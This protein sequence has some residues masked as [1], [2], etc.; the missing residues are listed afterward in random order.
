MAELL[1]ENDIHRYFSYDPNWGACIFFIALFALLTVAFL[2]QV[3]RTKHQRWLHCL[4]LFAALEMG[5]YIARIIMYASPGGDS[6]KAELIILILAPNLLAFCCYVVL[7]K[8]I[9]F[10]FFES[11]HST[12]PIKSTNWIVR[13]PQWIPRLYVASDILCLAIQGAGGGMLSG[14][15]TNSQIDAGKGV[16]VTGLV[17]QLFFVA[18]F[19]LICLYV[20]VQVKRH[21][22]QRLQLMKPAFLVLTVII[23]LLVL[24]NAYRTAEFASGTF[25]TGYFQENEAWYLVFDPTL[26]SIALMV[27]LAFDFTKR[28]PGSD[29]P[30]LASPT[31]QDVE[32]GM[33]SPD[34]AA[35]VVEVQSEDEEVS[36]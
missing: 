15:T 8:M 2:I 17:L 21:S 9:R 26:M 5:G 12:D 14:A 30:A 34:G 1:P 7:G 18:T 19:V 23:V 27:A 11:N 22:P 3:E 10:A 25:T 20:Y 29:A 6:F 28:L 24:R 4:T 13:H 32:M 31:V 36:Q 35:R 16:E 33:K